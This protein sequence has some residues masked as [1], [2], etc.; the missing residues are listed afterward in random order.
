MP[1]YLVLKGKKVFDPSKTRF[2]DVSR[3]VSGKRFKKVQKI[4]FYC[5]FRLQFF[6]NLQ[7]NFLKRRLR[8]RILRASPQKFWVPDFRGGAK[9]L[10]GGAQGGRN[11]SEGEGRFG[12]RPP[13]PLT[14]PHVGTPGMYDGLKNHKNIY[15]KKVQIFWLKF[16][17]DPNSSKNL[18]FGHF[19]PKKMSMTII[20]FRKIFLVGT[21][22]EWFKIY[23]K[24]IISILKFFP[25]KIF[26]R[27]IAVFRTNGNYSLFGEHASIGKGTCMHD[28][29]KNP[30]P[31]LSKKWQM[32]KNFRN[33]FGRN[34]FRMAQNVI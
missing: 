25:M 32:K 22:L 6:E 28:G 19:G 17:F 8:R 21:A 18:I 10:K 9:S 15:Q 20:F 7:K 24:T 31:F 1:K 5:I 11:F 13:R 26:F 29:L 3:G 14:L 4:E 16:F 12:L 23:F 27:D 33:C 2:L 30:Q 34:R